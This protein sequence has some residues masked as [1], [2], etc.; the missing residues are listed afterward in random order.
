MIIVYSLK[1]IAYLAPFV[2]AHKRL[3]LENIGM[4]KILE[5]ECFGILLIYLYDKESFS[6]S[7]LFLW[8]PHNFFGNLTDVN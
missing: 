1:C 3:L 8:Y 7:P 2:F 6:H 5:D 4:Q